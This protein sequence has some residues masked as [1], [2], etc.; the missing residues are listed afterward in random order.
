MPRTYFLCAVCAVIPRTGQAD[1]LRLLVS[2]CSVLANP[3]EVKVRYYTDTS[4]GDIQPSWDLGATS[5]RLQL[6]RY[7]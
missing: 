4:G 2:Y 6:T 1:Y 7:L 5:S 3:R